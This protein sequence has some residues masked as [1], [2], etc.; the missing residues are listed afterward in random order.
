MNRDR[1]GTRLFWNAVFVVITL[2][3]SLPVALTIS[4]AFGLPHLL[5]VLLVTWPAMALLL[6]LTEGWVVAQI[7]LMMILV[8]IVA[9]ME[10]TVGRLKT[11][12]RSPK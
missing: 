9:C 5:T 1:I 6:G 3:I 8:T 12:W 10:A 7:V 2:V 4:Y 11:K